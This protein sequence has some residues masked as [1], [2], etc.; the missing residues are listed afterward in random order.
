[1][2][3]KNNYRAKKNEKNFLLIYF[4]CLVSCNDSNYNEK[5][6]QS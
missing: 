2:L 5:I 6:S 4:I 3:Q 1:M